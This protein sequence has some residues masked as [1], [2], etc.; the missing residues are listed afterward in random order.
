VNAAVIYALIIM[1]SVSAVLKMEI[2][3]VPVHQTV[4]IIFVIL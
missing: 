3:P 1:E 2:H 4:V